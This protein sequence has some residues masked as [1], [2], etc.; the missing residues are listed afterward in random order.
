MFEVSEAPSL[1]VECCAVVPA[2]DK[3]VSYGTCVQRRLFRG[4]M[5][6]TCQLNVCSDT[7][8]MLCSRPGDNMV[9]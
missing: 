9:L 4:H 2:G 8:H 7:G 6:T 3:M 1:A 5:S